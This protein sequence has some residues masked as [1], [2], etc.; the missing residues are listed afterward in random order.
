MLGARATLA[1]GFSLVYQ[2]GY[3]I[4][5]GL[6]AALFQ[7]TSI[8]TTTGFATED[9]EKWRPVGQLILLALMFVGGCTGSTAGGLKVARIVLLLRIVHRDFKRLVHRHGVFAVRLGSHV[10]PETSIQSLLNL[11]YLAFLVNFMACLLLAA[12][13]VDVLTSISAVAACMFNVG[14]GL[15]MVGPAEHYGHLPAVAKW[16]LSGCMLAGRLEFYTA[17]VILTPVYWRR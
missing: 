1:V 14:P 15:G 16:V 4:A 8:M 2:D 10:I 9:F 5:R 3:P 6:R 17:L 13:G 7:V 12:S 11:V